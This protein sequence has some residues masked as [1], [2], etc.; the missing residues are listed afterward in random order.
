M[1]RKGVTAKEKRVR[2]LKSKIA[3]RAAYSPTLE[4]AQVYGQVVMELKDLFGPLESKEVLAGPVYI[5]TARINQP[6]RSRK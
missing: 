5:Q 6:V 3:A 1:V 4:Y 2:L